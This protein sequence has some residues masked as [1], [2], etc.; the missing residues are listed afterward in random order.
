[1]VTTDFT[2]P[3]DQP[4]LYGENIA[5]LANL[6]GNTVI[7]QKLGDLLAG[8]RST[9]VR[10]KAGGIKPTLKAATPGDLSYVLPYRHLTAIMEMIR[11]M[12][13]I[14]PGIFSFDTLLYGVEVK[15]YSSAPKL[16]S[17]LETEVKNLYAVGDGAGV[18]RN[19]THASITGMVAAEAIVRKFKKI[20]S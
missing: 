14:A 1:M 7:V 19:L 4:T 20:V 8:R 13:K 6:L 18:S 5:R 2:Y 11:Q 10:I 9:E 16:T 15:F 3:F 17:S 12:D